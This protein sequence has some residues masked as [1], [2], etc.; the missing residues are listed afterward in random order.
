MDARLKE[1]AKLGFR[2]ALAPDGLESAAGMAV[3][4]A[5]RLADVLRRIRDVDWAA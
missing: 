2:K 1:A 5:H 4:G 3:S